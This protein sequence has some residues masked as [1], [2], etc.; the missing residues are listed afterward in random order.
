[1]RFI[2]FLTNKIFIINLV[3]AIITAIIIYLMVVYGLK[4]YTQH[5]EKIAVPSFVSLTY[6]DA[7]ELAQLNEL[8]VVVVDTSYSEETERGLIAAQIPA[9]ASIVKQGRTIYLTINST[10]AELISM[11]NFKGASLRQ[12]LADAKIYG[13]KIGEL[14]YVPDIAKNNVLEQKINGKPIVPGTKV[15]KGSFIDLVLGM[16]LSNEKVFIPLLL[17]QSLSAADSMLRAKY[18]NAGA[19]FYDETVKTLEDSSMAIIYKQE[20][21]PFSKD[22]KPGDFVDLWLSKDSNKVFIKQA[23]KDSM[24]IK[25]DTIPSITETEIE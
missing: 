8:K 22:F 10:E 6:E 1:M 20:P 23:W 11:P 9:E 17:N 15:E 16:G 12:A 24:K 5:G 18:L 4:I 14:T 19:K 7:R 3:V 25:I 13:L 21:E 2:K